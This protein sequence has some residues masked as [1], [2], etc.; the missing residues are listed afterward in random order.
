MFNVTVPCDSLFVV[1]FEAGIAKF[2][3]TRYGAAS[4]EL[5][6]LTEFEEFLKYP[7]SAL[8]AFFEKGNDIE[9]F[10]LKYADH[11]RGEYRFGHSSAAE[12]LSKYNQK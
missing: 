4:T 3:K 12:V 1:F 10:F 5:S 2:M 9:T 11:Y 6:T 8:I 7:E